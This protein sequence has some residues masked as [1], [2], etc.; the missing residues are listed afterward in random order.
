MQTIE[1]GP[2]GG[3]LVLLEELCAEKWRAPSWL[4]NRIGMLNERG[5]ISDLRHRWG[6]PIEAHTETVRGRRRT[7]Y[8][9]PRG[10]RREARR[11]IRLGRETESEQIARR[12][13]RAG[14]AT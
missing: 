14:R 13:G 6:V 11:L 8:A 4:L 5:R 3:C 7:E 10:H 2:T 9:V 1:R 12:A